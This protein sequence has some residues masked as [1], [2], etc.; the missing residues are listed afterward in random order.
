MNDET[1]L[2]LHTIKNDSGNYLWNQNDNTIL[3]K[4]VYI[5]NYMPDAVAGN[6][7]IA[8]GDFSYYWIIQRFPFTVRTMKEL[9]AANQQVAYLGYE[10]LDAKLIRPEAIK[11]MQITDTAAPSGSATTSSRVTTAAKRR[12]CMKKT[13]RNGSYEPSAN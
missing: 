4:S 6:K 7:P 3:G 10:H 11:V 2:A 5:S 9:Y 1:A 13:S 8:F 12:I